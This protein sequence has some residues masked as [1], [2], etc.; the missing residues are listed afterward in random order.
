MSRPRTF[1]ELKV[2]GHRPRTVKDEMRAN[3]ITSL[4]GGGAL[5]PGIV[6]YET[7]V[8]PQVVNAILSRH[9]F[10]LLGLRGQAKTRILRSLSRFLDEWVPAI[11]GC[12]LNSDPL[13]P[14]THHARLTLD[15]KGD[16]TPLRW[17]HRDERYQE[18]LATPD[19]TIADL[20]G[21]IDPIKAATL[22]LDRV[23]VADD[24]REQRL[25]GAQAR[26][27]VVAQLVLH[28]P[29][30]VAGGLELAQGA[31]AGHRGDSFEMDVRAREHP[32]QAR[33]RRR[34]APGGMG[35][36]YGLVTAHSSAP[37]RPPASNRA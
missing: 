26:D 36:A 32:C 25:A 35:P 16:D 1:G 9:D 19:V 31:G 21:D 22:R 13:L 7:T 10:I 37:S 29:V 6:G 8:E 2:A 24:A 12:P 11:E 4:R 20:I 27:H 14:L 17:L 34:P 33:V 30:A 3:L 18:K 15:A 5:F 23:L 28:G